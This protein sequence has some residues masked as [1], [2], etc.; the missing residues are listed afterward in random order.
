MERLM[1][2]LLALGLGAAVAVLLWQTWRASADRKATRA[3]FLDDC[4]AL[5]TSGLKARAETGFARLSGQYRDQTFDVQVVPDTLTFRKL[6]TLWLLVTLPVVL[7][8]RATFDLMLRP[9]GMESFSRHA[10]YPEQIAT[11]PGFPEGS[12]IRTDDPA[13]LPS[14]TVLHR[15]LNDLARSDRFKELVVSPKGLRIVWLAEEADRGRYLLFRDAEMGQHPLDP[16]VL[17]PLMDALLALLADLQA[18]ESTAR[19]RS[20]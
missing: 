1:L 8:L 6:P 11:P 5:F 9:T 2:G 10:S 14:E 17:R 13:A 4:Q 18:D 15:H 3:G 12:S 16:A 7:P 19:S 20:A